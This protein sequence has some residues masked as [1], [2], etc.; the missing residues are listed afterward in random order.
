MKIDRNICIWAS[1]LE[2]KWNNAELEKN[3]LTLE[4]FEPTAYG[5]ALIIKYLCWFTSTSNHFRVNFFLSIFWYQRFLVL[6]GFYT[7]FTCPDWLFGDF[8]LKIFLG[9]FFTC[10]FSKIKR[11][12]PHIER[13]NKTVWCLYRVRWWTIL[14][15]KVDALSEWIIGIYLNEF[16]DNNEREISIPHGALPHWRFRVHC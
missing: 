4:G 2:K 6:F 8:R 5:L 3:S 7:L 13:S 16:T 14:C 15:L 10:A 1:A 9:S 11:V 12:W